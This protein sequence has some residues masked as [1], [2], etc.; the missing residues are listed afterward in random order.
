MYLY[1]V[2][3]HVKTPNQIQ[4]QDHALEI[5][6]VIFKIEHTAFTLL[7][8]YIQSSFNLQP[9]NNNI[10]GLNIHRHNDH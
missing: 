9:V 6:D 5:F 10:K 2:Q 8:F 1:I 3:Y 4:D 7:S